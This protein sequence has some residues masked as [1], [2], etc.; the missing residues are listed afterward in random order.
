M[1]SLDKLEPVKI[2]TD[3]DSYSSFIFGPAKIGKTTFVENMAPGRVLHIM[4]EMR[5]KSLGGAMVIYVSKFSDYLQVMT[6]LRNPK[7]REK[8][9]IVSI[10]TV[11]NLHRMLEKYVAQK[12]EEDQIGERNDLFGKDW[13]MLKGMWFDA[14]KKPE[15]LGYIP[16]FVSHSVQQTIHVPKDEI[17]STGEDI[18]TEYTEVKNK[19]DG[20]TYLEFSRYAPNLKDKEFAPI[21]NMVDNILFFNNTIDDQGNQIRV[22]HLRPSLQWV[23]GSTFKEIE[24]MIPLSVEDYGKALKKAIKKESS[25]KNDFTDKRQSDADIN[26][27]AVPFAELQNELQVVA[28][29]YQKRN[30]FDKL[31]EISA[32]VVGKGNKVTELKESQSEILETAINALKAGLEE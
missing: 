21:N 27:K 1:I 4:T 5:F 7:Y 19:K 3:I 32:S 24:P 14:L 29:E 20:K 9:D 30:M 12:F 11:E 16:N 17:K 31:T 23:A 18:P 8:F 25:N 22:I 6:Q 13:S 28:K 10:D 26:D 15:E 2:S